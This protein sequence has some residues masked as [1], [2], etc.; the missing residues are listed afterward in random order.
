M[1]GRRLLA[2]ELTGGVGE[3]ID[4]WQQRRPLTAVPGAV[5][6]KY[7]D[8]RGGRL[9]SH[10][11][12]SAFLAVFPLLL[13]L[14]TVVGIV[15]DGHPAWQDDVVDSALRQFPVVGSDLGR[16]VHQLSTA[17]TFAL[18]VGLVWL[19]Y[20]SMKLS[21]SAQVMMAVVWDVDR[22]DLPRLGQWIPRA[23]GFLVVLG[24]GFIAGGALAGLGAFGG[25]GDASA[26]V[27]PAL[28]LVVNVAMYAAAFTVLLRVPGNRRSVWPGAVVG[29]VGW[30][31]LQFVGAE[32]VSHQLRHL[33][34]LYGTF[35]TV[36][37]LIWWL[38]LGA[39]LTVVA[40][41]LNVVL[42]RHLWPRTLRR[43]G[44]G[45]VAVTPP[46]STA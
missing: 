40:A 46:A 17:N 24:I 12:Y 26:V 23:I 4:G 34:N 22:D 1:G 42:A 20:G 19:L 9:A 33:S 13:V 6:R 30:T 37:G 41:E 32:L 8:D 2:G 14:L 21:R 36:L 45:R 35:A 44:T 28:S 5:A 39:M 25:L 31:L 18:V 15:L 11:S 3:R 27:G 38:A 29:G 7:V 10:I 43:L 16:N